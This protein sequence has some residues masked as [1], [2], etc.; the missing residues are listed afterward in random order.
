MTVMAH[1][2][3]EVYV[4]LWPQITFHSSLLYLQGKEHLEER[5]LSNCT[6][7]ENPVKVRGYLH[8]TLQITSEVEIP[9]R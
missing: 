4:W 1:K 2:G 6:M 9:S 7:Y 3:C 5:A 8:I